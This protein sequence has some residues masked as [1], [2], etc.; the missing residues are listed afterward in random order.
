MQ[1]DSKFNSTKYISQIF[2][3]SRVT[4]LSDDQSTLNANV[5]AQS[6]ANH[7]ANPIAMP[8]NF[9]DNPLELLNDWPVNGLNCI[10]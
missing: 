3:N 6:V 2:K 1:R 5:T 4:C 7:S 9:I 10:E 8:I